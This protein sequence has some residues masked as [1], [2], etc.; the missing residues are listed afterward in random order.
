VRVAILTHWYPEREAD[1]KAT[2]VA[3]R[4][5]ALA[6]R[7]DVTV[8]HAVPW[9]RRPPLGRPPGP[10]VRHLRF[11]YL[12]L[13]GKRFDG[14]LLERS[15]RAALAA[16][17]PDVVEAQFGYPDGEAAV[18]VAAALGCRSAV[19]LRGTEQVLAAAGP[20]RARLEE[21]LARADLVLPV[22]A[23][24]AE[25]A[26]GL[27][28][29]EERLHVVP[30]GVD[31]ELF[32]PGD[33]DAARE[34]LRLPREG[35]LLLGVGHLTPMKGHDASIRALARLLEGA[36]DLRL[37]VVGGGSDRQ[38]L[39][40]VARALGV[41]G[42]VTLAGVQPPARMPLWYQAADLLSHPSHSEGRPNAVLE[43]KACG[44]PAVATDVGGTRELVEV[45]ETG[46]LVPPRDLDALVSGLGRALGT[47]F[48][49]AEVSRRGRARSWADAAL[50][51]EGLYRGL[52]RGA[53][54]G[55][56]PA[57]RSEAAAGR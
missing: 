3:A 44:L 39:E 48:D 7:M 22:S 14:R 30:N 2:F 8:V 57:L 10:P 43:A 56:R 11:V 50:Q 19:T 35:R 5:A 34:A 20:R 26:R 12:P 25:F 38:R 47:A 54:G 52:P 46:L 23:A 21:A 17:G 16:L 36:P 45:G 40:G 6:E 24:L 49:R 29:V 9:F 18:R 41:E 37:A 42:R 51:L 27:G 4:A 15:A 32:R 31:G 28:A 53:S 1:W 33:R 13:L 55:A